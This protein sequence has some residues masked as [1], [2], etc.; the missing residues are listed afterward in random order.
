MPKSETITTFEQLGDLPKLYSG[1]ALG[2]DAQCPIKLF[3]PD[4]GWIWYPTESDGADILFGLA[5]GFEAELGYFALSD[6][7][8]AGLPIERDLDYTPTTL[9]AIY[10]LHGLPIIVLDHDDYDADQHAA[11]LEREGIRQLEALEDEANLKAYYAE[12]GDDAPDPLTE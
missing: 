7:L 11:E 12:H 8:A 4:S 2:L 9:R 1:E 10:T 6:L 3:S 5:L